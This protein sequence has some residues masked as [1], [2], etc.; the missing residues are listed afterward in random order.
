MEI[1]DL[2]KVVQSGRQRVLVSK[3]ITV[4][5]YLHI[6][7]RAVLFLY[8][9]HVAL[10]PNRQTGAITPAL[11][12]FEWKLNVPILQQHGLSGAEVLNL[13]CAKQLEDRLFELIPIYVAASRSIRNV[14]PGFTMLNEAVIGTDSAGTASTGYEAF[15]GL[16]NTLR[17]YYQK[18]NETQGNITGLKQLYTFTFGTQATPVYTL[19]VSYA[20]IQGTLHSKLTEV[21]KKVCDQNNVLMAILPI[22]TGVT[23][24]LLVHKVSTF[25]RTQ[26]MWISQLHPPKVMNTI[27]LSTLYAVDPDYVQHILRNIDTFLRINIGDPQFLQEASNLLGITEQYAPV[28]PDNII[29]ASHT[30]IATQQ[31]HCKQM[32]TPTVNSSFTTG[33]GTIEIID[34][35]VQQ[36]DNKLVITYTVRQEIQLPQIQQQETTAKPQVTEPQVEKQ[37]IQDIAP[38]N[39]TE[40]VIAEPD[41]QPAKTLDE[42]LANSQEQNNNNISI[43]DLFKM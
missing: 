27:D 39:T 29:L 7:N 12:L 40:Q 41:S 11:Q 6:D 3:P 28:A 25:N 1:Q 43:D 16:L 14:A 42:Q 23:I 10:L 36:H 2:F 24:P 13:Y 8:T 35:R 9:L 38:K 5:P 37:E 18:V 21:A 17:N 33:D 31:P 30:P 22:V 4:F 19:E 32:R 34:Y 20:T 15:K 26:G